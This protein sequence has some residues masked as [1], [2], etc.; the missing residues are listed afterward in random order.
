MWPG[1]EPSPPI[2]GELLWPSEDVYWE[3]DV[4]LGGW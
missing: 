3:I 4:R 2:D 1:A